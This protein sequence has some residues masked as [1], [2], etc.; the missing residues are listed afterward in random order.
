MNAGLMSMQISLT[1]R[2]EIVGEGRNGLS[3]LALRSKHHAGLVDINKPSDNIILEQAVEPAVYK[4]S[5]L[6]S[7][8]G[9]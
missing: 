5:D 6:G 4:S 1:A 2:G 9:R 3:D 7:T 8:T